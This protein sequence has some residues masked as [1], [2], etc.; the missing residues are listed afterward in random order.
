MLKR[1]NLT[2]TQAIV[3]SALAIGLGAGAYTAS[4]Q[5]PK[6][7]FV[8]QTSSDTPAPTVTLNP[9]PTPDSTPST[10]T[11]TTAPDRTAE[12][13]STPAPTTEAPVTQPVAPV[14][15]T[16]STY[17]GDNTSGV[18]DLTYSDDTTAQVPATL[19][20]QEVSFKVTMTTNNCDSF[21]GQT[22]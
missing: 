20:T 3:L 7:T 1:I 17:S 18:C 9:G 5:S 19:T 12:P 22:K 21:I 11:S 16:K 10:T 13:A 6:H 4:T 15:V 2:T 8:K 14:T